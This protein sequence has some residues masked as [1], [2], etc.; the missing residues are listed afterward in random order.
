M[1]SFATPEPISVTAHVGAG[2][3]LFTAGDRLDTVI[4]ARP[5]DPKRDKDVRA[6]EQT[7]VSYASGVLTVRTKERRMLGPSGVVD[8][9]VELPTGSHVD[10][11]AGPRCSVRAGSARSGSR[12]RSATSGS[13]RPAR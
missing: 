8:V 13:T 2:S 10:N 11:S 6:A 4:H 9:T 1:P 12:P 5:R 3:I 7:E